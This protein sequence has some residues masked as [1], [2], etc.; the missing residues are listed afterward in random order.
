MD[1]SMINKYCSLNNECN[2]VMEDV[3]RKWALSARSFHK[4]L[5]VARTIA[6]MNESGDIEVNHLLEA[7]SYRMPDQFTS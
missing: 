6:D 4:I 1:S 2:K 7:L 3:F 5:R